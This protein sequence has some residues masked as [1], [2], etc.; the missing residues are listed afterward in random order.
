MERTD[1]AARL[2][3][4]AV[5]A[6]DGDRLRALF[7]EH[8]GLKE[9]IDEPWFAFESPAFVLLAKRGNREAIDAL[10]DAGAD[11]NAKSAW[12]AGGYTALDGL[13]D[14]P[15]PVDVDFAEYLIS[16]GA[17]VDVHAA[18]G[19]GK[20]DR[21]KELLDAAPDRVR[22][23]GPDGATPLHLAMNVE[24]ARFLLDRGAEIDQRCVD[25][26][27]TAAQWSVSGTLREVFPHR[28]TI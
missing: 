5:E 21:L 26:S 25:H 7:V 24:I 6:A 13:V 10:L 3:Q 1:E 23:P 27:S 12:D 4:E 2:F 16:R 14:Q 18:A 9:V 28:S 11:P 8:P 15:A 22:E 17:V 20:L 19:L